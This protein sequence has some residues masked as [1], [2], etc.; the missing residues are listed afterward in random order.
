MS[1][2][3]DRQPL[4]LDLQQTADAIA[5]LREEVGRVVVGQQTVVE[6]MLTA[7]VA[8]GHCLL[9]GVPGLAKTV[10][11][12]ALADALEMQFNRVQFTPDLMPSDITGT[13]VLQEDPDTGQK[14]FRFL[15]GPI[16]T[17]VLLAD[18]INR[19]PPKTQASLLEAMQERSVT[20]GDAS[21]ELPSPFFVIATQ[22]P[23]EQEGTYPLPEA[24]LDRFMFSVV[25]N[26]PSHAEENQIVAA[27]TAG[28]KVTLNKILSTEHVLAMQQL[29]RDSAA[30]PTVT[31][32][33]VT[34]A[35]ATRP[36]NEEAPEFIQK[37]LDCG[38]GPRAGQYLTLAAKARAVLLG[39]ETATVE[40]VRAAAIPVLRHRMFTNFTALS[41]GIDSDVLIR[42]LVK[43]VPAPSESKPIVYEAPGGDSPGEPVTLDTDLKAVELIHRMKTITRRIRDEVQQTVIGQTEV[44]DLVLTSLLAGGHCLLVGVPGLAKTT[45]VQ[46][47]AQVLDL[48][49]KRVQFTPDLMPSDITGT[50]IMETDPT[51]Q[52]RSFRFIPGPIF[53]NLLLADEIN[54]TPPKTQA[55]LLEAMQ[56][57]CV[58][59]GGTTY[60]LKPPFFVLATQ[61]PLEQEGTYPLPEAQLDRFMFNLHLDYPTQDEEPIIID[62]TT[63][64]G[65]RKPEKVIDAETI[66]RLQQ[67]VR[68]VPVSQHVL[69]YVTTLVRA[70]RPDNK[71]G[72]QVVNQYVHCGAGPRAA[73]NLV[74]GAKARAVMHGRPNVSVNDVRAVAVPVLRHRIFTN[75]S[76]DAEG[77]TPMKIV[78]HL[79]KAVKEPEA[80]DEQALSKSSA[81]GGEPIDTRCPGC[82]KTLR[83]NAKA[84]GRKARCPSCSTVFRVEPMMA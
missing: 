13:N 9:I 59:S 75:F 15:P 40:D 57:M 82:G 39:R 67:V 63:G 80:K 17:N 38:A 78:A 41:E 11:A 60:P 54:R 45:L 66:V 43:A 47:I 27:T 61:N 81:G 25:V 14:V 76:A 32:Y 42:Q 73:Q 58:T 6:Q 2:A 16:F 35:R 33:A 50:D 22:N 34:L 31:R 26:Y 24:Q 77:V 21:R 52:E 53:T 12:K 65:G 8:R 69:T 74:L 56:E 3:T 48:E 84:A 4:K 10:M 51:T 44:L 18:E 20:T 55:A 62:R 19:T 64:K 71:T 28:K 23:L 72:D 7:L 37:Y 30:P 79:V 5:K 68:Q 1:T 46:T 49:F 29:V 83:L 36:G 70:T